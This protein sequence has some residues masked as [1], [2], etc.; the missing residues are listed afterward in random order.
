[1]YFWL[2]GNRCSLCTLYDLPIAN[3][4]VADYQSMTYL[5]DDEDG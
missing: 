5:T 1:M 4:I 3:E 2:H